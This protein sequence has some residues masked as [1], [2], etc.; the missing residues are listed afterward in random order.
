[1]SEKLSELTE[2]LLLDDGTDTK[3]VLRTDVGWI[4][5]WNSELLFTTSIADELFSHVLWY[6]RAL[7]DWYGVRGRH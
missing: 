5:H 2:S 3:D 4:R 6:S 7:E 1:M